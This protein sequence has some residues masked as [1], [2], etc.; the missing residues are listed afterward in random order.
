MASNPLLAVSGSGT[1]L[2]T[3]F[4]SQFITQTPSITSVFPDIFI[5]SRVGYTKA[6]IVDDPPAPCRTG[7][8]K[9]SERRRLVK[10][11]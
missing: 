5:Y 9:A 4:G 10:R 2:F 1:F 8:P 6:A 11:H 7:G 3:S